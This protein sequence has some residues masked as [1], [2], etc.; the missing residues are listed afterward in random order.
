MDVCKSDDT[1]GPSLV[2]FAIR[3]QWSDFFFQSLESLPSIHI[4]TDIM[5]CMGSR[6]EKPVFFLFLFLS[7]EEWNVEYGAGV[8]LS[9]VFLLYDIY[10]VYTSWIVALTTR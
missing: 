10:I 2:R 8:V 4:I 7:F 5:P 9:I 3:Y 6:E 1:I